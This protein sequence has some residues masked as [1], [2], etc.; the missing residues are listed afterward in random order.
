MPEYLADPDVDRSAWLKLR[1][2]GVTA[3]EISTVLGINPYDSPFALWHRKAGN[4]PEEPPESE[5]MRWGRLHE[6]TIAAE[7]ARRHDGWRLGPPGLYANTER[8]WQLATVDRLAFLDDG[9]NLSAVMP[10]GVLELKT[11]QGGHDWGPSGS[12]EIPANVL[13]QVR[14]QLDVM[15][16]EVG[17]IAVL[18]GLSDY[19]EYEIVPDAAD[20]DLMR[21]SALAFLQT[22]AEAKPPAV[23]GSEATTRALHRLHR[24]VDQVE[25]M[26]PRGLVRR[27]RAAKRRHL[28]ATDALDLASNQIAARLGNAR[29]GYWTPAAGADPRKAI[30]RSVFDQHRLDAKALRA[31]HPKLAKR[32]DRVTEVTRLTPAQDLIAEEDDHP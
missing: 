1:R 17:H 2:D 4:L 3:S 15:D 31:D 29:Y 9:D 26:L 20:T 24:R 16:A 22:L 12:D 21:W 32:Y 8:P 13:A 6:A 7:W 27:Y 30:T 25:V 18:V 19:R 11:N 23:D 14:W 28:A 5:A 10:I